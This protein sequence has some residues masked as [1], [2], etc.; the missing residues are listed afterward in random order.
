MLTENLKQVI[1][2]CWADFQEYQGTKP[3]ILVSP[4]IPILW[5][6]NL[7]EYQKSK[8]KVVTV[9]LNP[10]NVEFAE[11]KN[12]KEFDIDLR[13]SKANGL[14]KSMDNNDIVKY[15]EA[16]NDYFIAKPYKKWFNHFEQPIN[17]L[18]SSYN[19]SES[20]Q[21]NCAVHIDIY[22]PLATN[23]TWGKLK[24][25]EK[26][27]LG[28][29]KKYFEKMLSELNPD[30]I[31]VSA[32]K[33][34]LNQT[35]GISVGNADY[36]KKYSKGNGFIRSHKLDNKLIISGLNMGGIPFG[37]M[38]KDFISENIS[39]IAKNNNINI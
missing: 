11:N 3:S 9:G 16:M 34:V 32:N 36:H 7:E 24:K 20:A 8:L 21:K 18:N 22:A 23:P 39:C 26:D 28:E 27:S 5:F 1:S 29:F 19:P 6:G 10:S 2:D 35:F 4:S 13:F 25:E 30:V 37:G 33:E 17:S 12:S 31:F 38:S 15:Y 14:K